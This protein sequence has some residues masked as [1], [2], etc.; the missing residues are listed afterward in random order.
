MIV[1]LLASSRSCSSTEAWP[2]S[3][4]NRPRESGRRQRHFSRAQN[5]RRRGAWRFACGASLVALDLCAVGGGRAAVR[6]TLGLAWLGLAWLGLAAVSDAHRPFM[7]ACAAIAPPR[8]LLGQL[9][10][11]MLQRSGGSP[12][13]SFCARPP[14]PP[15]LSRTWRRHSSHLLVPTSTAPLSR[16][17]AASSPRLAARWALVR[18]R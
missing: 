5:P 2:D 10:A 7:P 9:Q 15:R 14:P 12:R 4:R 16:C 3:W 8:L 18:P 13:I 11:W 6:V 17:T 1:A